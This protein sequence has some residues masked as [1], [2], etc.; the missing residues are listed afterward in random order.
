MVILLLG[1]A[2]SP[3]FD[4]AGLAALSCS[5][6]VESVSWDEQVDGVSFGELRDSVVGRQSFLNQNPD[7][8]FTEISVLLSASEDTPA[9]V[10]WEG[11][12]C[13]EPEYR[14]PLSGR[15]EI[16]G[17]AANS[18][19]LCMLD[20][21][22][23]LQ[24]IGEIQPDEELEAELQAY[25]PEDAGSVPDPPMVLDWELDQGT[26]SVE[27]WLTFVESGESWYDDE[28]RRVDVLMSDWVHRAGE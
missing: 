16:A 19:A 7:E 2:Q 23:H 14:V 18:D 25:G 8:L 20:Q 28:E 9:R 21:G 1:C 12:G 13:P 15:W 27:L 5:S 11:E 24:C 26:A 17:V 22:A 3:E 6:T 10:T 4:P